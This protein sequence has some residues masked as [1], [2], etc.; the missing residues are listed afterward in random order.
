[1]VGSDDH[2]F[3]VALSR[4]DNSA[5][6]QHGGAGTHDGTESHRASSEDLGVQTYVGEALQRDVFV[7][8]GGVNQQRLIR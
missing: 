8:D 6:L 5:G 2:E 1:M 3:L 4:L 7:A